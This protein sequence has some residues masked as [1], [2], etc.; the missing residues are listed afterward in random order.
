MDAKYITSYIFIIEYIPS[1][2]FSDTVFSL[3]VVDSIIDLILVSIIQYHS[4]ASLIDS[5]I[6]KP[7]S[8][9]FLLVTHRL[10][11]GFLRIQHPISY[12]LAVPSLLLYRSIVYILEHLD[13]RQS[14]F[15]SYFTTPKRSTECIQVSLPLQ[16]AFVAYHGQ[17]ILET[18]IVKRLQVL[19]NQKSRSL[20][21]IQHRKVGIPLPY[22]DLPDPE[23][24]VILEEKEIMEQARQTMVPACFDPQSSVTPWESFS[25]SGICW[26]IFLSSSFATT[27]PSCRMCL[28]EFYA[29]RGPIV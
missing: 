4:I 14:S 2:S 17:V 25:C 15:F 18:R 29:F 20:W 28:C 6:S 1:W 11:D 5:L 27:A 23:R 22:L 19:N 16:P 12:R 8:R 7:M 13:I 3:V 10:I 24:S 21:R 26:W 9:F